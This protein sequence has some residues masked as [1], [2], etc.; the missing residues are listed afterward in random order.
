MT[1]TFACDFETTVYNGQTNTEVWSSALV[2]LGTEE[3]IIHHSIK[4]TLDYFKGLGCD[5]IAYYHNL[6]FDGSFWLDYIMRHTD[7]ELAFTYFNEKQDKGEWIEDKF[8]KPNSYKYLISNMGQW[9]TMTL[10]TQKGYKI[11]LKD[12][13]KLMPFTLAEIG[14]AFKTKHKK[15]TMEYEGKRYSGCE[16][17]EEEKAYIENDVLV[18]KEALEFMFEQGHKKL[19][20]G[21]CC[22][23]EFKQMPFSVWQDEEEYKQMFP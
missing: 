17:T 11:V 21:S 4:E 10:K 6:K 22:L 8:M 2:E 9:Y 20:I 13:L 7:F 14:K 5:V 15:L 19:T 1:R 3:V 18:L 12:S 23:S 16:I